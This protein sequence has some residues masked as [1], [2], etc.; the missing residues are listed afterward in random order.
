MLCR[1]RQPVTTSPRD[2]ARLQQPDPVIAQQQGV[3][4]IAMLQACFQ[5]QQKPRTTV[6]LSGVASST[7]LYIATMTTSVR[8]HFHRVAQPWQMLMRRH[9]LCHHNKLRCRAN[10]AG[11]LTTMPH[12]LM[13]FALPLQGLSLSAAED[14]LMQAGAVGTATSRCRSRTSF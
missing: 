13:L 5:T 11:V 8:C 3:D 9:C 4:V 14:R 12:M 10:S 2:L 6:Y 1:A 7:L